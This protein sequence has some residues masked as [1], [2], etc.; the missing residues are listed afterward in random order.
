MYY[1][2]ETRERLKHVD[3][4]AII[5]NLKCYVEYLRES[6]KLPTDGLVDYWKQIRDKPLRSWWP[7]YWQYNDIINKDYTPK[8]LM[9]SV[10]AMEARIQHQLIHYS[11][12]KLPNKIKII[13]F[14]IVT[15]VNKLPQESPALA[16]FDEQFRNSKKDGM[17]KKYMMMTSRINKESPNRAF[18]I[19]QLE[20]WRESEEKKNKRENNFIIQRTRVVEMIAKWVRILF[21][22]LA[23]LW[24][25]EQY[26]EHMKKIDSIEWV[27][28][29]VKPIEVD[30]QLLRLS[31]DDWRS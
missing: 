5:Y 30:A 16:V 1:F 18:V 8:I 13:D 2:F 25:K 31:P 15:N 10:E 3:L 20:D 14:W 7:N 4:L 22:K 19:F 27:L 26:K 12:S 17:K 21:T 11:L 29:S 6:G 9:K 24:S 28:D 23:E